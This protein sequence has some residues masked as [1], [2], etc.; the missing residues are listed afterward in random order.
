MTTGPTDADGLVDTVDPVVDATGA[1]PIETAERYTDAV[2]ASATTRTLGNN[3]VRALPGPAP[4][5]G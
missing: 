5:P 1:K 2:A 3:T 4:E